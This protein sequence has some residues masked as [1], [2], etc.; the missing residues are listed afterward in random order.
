M[1]V[2]NMKTIL[3]SQVLFGVSIFLLLLSTIPNS[4]FRFVGSSLFQKTISSS[5]YAILIDCIQVVRLQRDQSSQCR[6]VFVC[7]ILKS[8][9]HIANC[10]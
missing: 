9:T 5:S 8:T 2:I 7:W 10:S 3:Y 6:D 1:D 4:L